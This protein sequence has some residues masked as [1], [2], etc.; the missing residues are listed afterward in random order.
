MHFE[1]HKTRIHVIDFEKGHVFTTL[2]PKI[3]FKKTQTACYLIMKYAA[4]MLYFI[5]ILQENF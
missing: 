4:F 2:S 3:V 5:C 1:L